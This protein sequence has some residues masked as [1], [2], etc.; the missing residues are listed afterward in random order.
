MKLRDLS[1]KA[2]LAIRLGAIEYAS[3]LCVH[4]LSQFPGDLRT[5]TLLGQAFLEQSKLSEACQQFDRVLELDPE[6][7]AALSADGVA[8]SAAGQLNA[9]VR[10]FERAYEL[11][12][13]NTQV[14]DSLSRLYAQR[15]GSAVDLSAAPPVAMIR[16]Q[17]RH[18]DLERAID[19]AD[20]Y[21]L[22]RPGDPSVLLSRAEA[23]W[24]TGRRGDAE[25][26]CHQILARH[27]RVLKARL[28]L[29]QI[30]ASDRSTERDG[31][32][33]LHAAFVEDPGG[34]VS[35]PLFRGTTFSP[36][37][38]ADEI[39]MSVPDHLRAGPTEID[40]AL[41]SLP[42]STA[43]E[44]EGEWQ[45][46]DRS[47]S[48]GPSDE[49]TGDEA[50]PSQAGTDAPE[51]AVVECLLAV[52]CR[53]PLVARYGFDGFQR[54]ER[55]LQTVARELAFLGTRMLV[56]FLDDPGSM[57][58]HDLSPIWSTDPSDIKRAIGEL[59]RVVSQDDGSEVDGVLIIGGDDVVPFFHLA[60]PSDDDDAEI[61]SDNPYVATEG[62]AIYAPR[63]AIGRL[64]DGS[65]GNLS[66]LLRQTD[67]LLEVRR[68]PPSAESSSRLRQ[69][70]IAAL[71]AIGLAVSNSLSFGCAAS[72]WESVS[73]A[74]F[75]P[76]STASSLRLS[77]PVTA[78]GFQA[79]WIQGRRF[80]YFNLHG[81]LDA[82]AWYGQVPSDRSID[83][84]TLP[85]AITP[86]LLSEADFTA[87]IVFSEASHA[88][89]V[90]AKTATSSLALRFL[91]EGAAAF[92][93]STATAYG[94]VE[95]PLAGADLLGQLFWE[96]L[97]DG[98]RIG[99]ALRRAKVQYAD[100]LLERQGYLDG[101][102]QKTLLAFVLF[103]D[104]LIPVFQRLDDRPFDVKSD[105]DVPRVL[106]C[107]RPRSGADSRAVSPKVLR[108]AIEHLFDR[109]PEA[110]TGAV[111]AH[112]RKACAG[113][114]DQP[115]HHH[116]GLPGEPK[117]IEVIAVSARKELA[118]SDG[119]KIVKFARVTLGDPGG[120]V[121]C[122]VSR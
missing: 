115:G 101:D 100:D 104:P 77:P 12:P 66:L 98:E 43:D 24:R 79:Q 96:N 21:L 90:G 65:G 108:A 109:C 13:G 10:A 3:D 94:T 117:E 26:A 83:S 106:L 31:V 51:P 57:A 1:R 110:A 11:N 39:S 20:E 59:A 73:G 32:E 107:N 89:N 15:D 40:A 48:T 22:V 54:L 45:P 19:A 50:D 8:H 2:D 61:L 113:E 74:A 111:R 49:P 78:D 37:V 52:S 105:D 30:L 87:P 33:L 7:V 36:P 64:P 4:V 76:L 25:S 71:G 18:G 92:I 119:A 17:L 16:W 86:E 114:C 80:F 5:R 41:A 112:R 99:D 85:I 69:A 116:D 121:K 46:P 72:S 27:P 42:A 55:R 14:R 23:L 44:L 47:V 60:N 103:G 118:T 68:N 82:A 120:P 38:L 28:I 63:I 88:A 62:D 29:G 93:G 67:T 35:T 58:Q 70:G 6:N 102:D 34:I 9:A 84:L 53:G 56:A 91:S 75:A 122:L 97:R 95:P 81:A